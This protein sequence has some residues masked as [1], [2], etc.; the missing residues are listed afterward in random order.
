MNNKILL[1]N[2]ARVAT[3]WMDAHHLSLFYKANGIK[4]KRGELPFSIGNITRGAGAVRRATGPAG[5][6]RLQT[7]RVVCCSIQEQGAVPAW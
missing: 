7:V 3:V 4:L 1:R 5:E 6:A 2:Y